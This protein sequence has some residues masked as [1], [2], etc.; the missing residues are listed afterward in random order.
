MFPLPVGWT[1]ARDCPHP[2]CPRGA[3][4]RHADVPSHHSRSTQ[5]PEPC[6]HI[7]N[8]RLRLLPCGEVPAFRMTVVE[9]EIRIGSLRPTSRTFGDL[10][11]EN[12]YDSRN[13]DA[14]VVDEA[15]LELRIEPSRGNPRVRQPGKRDVVEDVVASKRSVGL[16]IDKEFSDVPVARYVVVD[17]PRGKRNRRSR[18]PV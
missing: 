1:R 15:A 8:D 18:Q 4:G 3:W 16:T 13:G 12:A 11:R 7:V 5:R 10:L 9:E 14:Q 17:H 2:Y 6:A